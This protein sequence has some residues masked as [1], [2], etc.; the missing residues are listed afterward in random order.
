MQEE[1][2]RPHLSASL[3]R[4]FPWK[5]AATLALNCETGGKWERHLDTFPLFSH[6]CYASG[7]SHW[8]NLE[9]RNQGSSNDEIEGLNFKWAKKKR[10]KGKKNVEKKDMRSRWARLTKEESP[11]HLCY[12]YV[13]SILFAKY[14][15]L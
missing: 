8:S 10:K 13:H 12:L 4:N 5:N 9:I 2:P 6:L 14:L 1:H 11:A 15:L 7:F 3:S